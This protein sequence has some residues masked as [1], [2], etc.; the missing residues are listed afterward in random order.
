MYLF[1]YKRYIRTIFLVE[2]YPTPRIFN[3][4]STLK[5]ARICG[6]YWTLCGG[7]ALPSFTKG[8]GFE[9]HVL[10]NFKLFNRWKSAHHKILDPLLIIK[11]TL[12]KPSYI[13]LVIFFQSFAKGWGFKLVMSGLTVWWIFKTR[14][15]ALPLDWTLNSP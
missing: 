8:W 12:I 7:I 11:H 5:T 15:M 13:A 9:N 10:Y 3:N 2:A 1:K 6:T 14:G 4:R